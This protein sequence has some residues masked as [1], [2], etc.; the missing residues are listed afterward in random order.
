MHKSS[1]C[2]PKRERK[3][4]VSP[5][6]SLSTRGSQTLILPFADY[7]KVVSDPIKF[8]SHLD[9][10]YQQYP[11]VFPGG[12][13]QGYR[14][15]DIRGS[16]KHPGYKI[17]RISLRVGGCYS[18]LPSEMMLYLSGSS[19]Y[20]SKGLLLRR[21]AVPYEVI[22][23]VIGRHAGFWE[24]AE[25]Q[26]GRV[27]IVGSLY[28]TKPI[29]EHLVADEKVTSING[30]EAVVAMTAADECVL[31]ASL[32]LTTD[33]QGLSQAYGIFKAEALCLQ[34][35]YKAKTVTL[36]GWK[37]SHQA[38]KY[39]FSSISIVLC[40]LHEVIKVRN[41][42]KKKPQLF[43]QIAELLWNVYRATHA[44]QFTEGLATTLQWAETHLNEHAKV[45]AK[46]VALAAK[47]EALL[48]S[49]QHQK[50]YRTSNQVDRPMNYL[51]RF[52][53]QIRYFHG[54]L[55]T[56]QL[57]VRAWAMIYN[58][59]PFCERTRKNKKVKHRFEQLN[60]FCYHENWLQNL[61][62]AASMNGYRGHHKI[63]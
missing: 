8:R 40:F 61:N 12:F 6:T 34:A 24:R 57:K 60:G 11:E 38:W 56:A 52:L 36:D 3:R 59:A 16:K 45:M 27:S 28:K 47:Q 29:S 41:V 33:T 39:L 48:V 10:C 63:Q 23:E 4:E 26:L 15:H 49:Y 2:A 50:C 44:E 18:I 25:Q 14:L 42:T 7:A 5:L 58:F 35:D 62:I 13:D 31:G 51:D 54:N 17:R 21:Y 19:D 53:Y 1:T 32:S 37:A 46:L 9:A 30:K 22:A 43:Y 55:A 20:I